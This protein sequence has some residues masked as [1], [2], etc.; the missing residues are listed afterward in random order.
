MKNG[1]ITSFTDLFAWKEGHK[2]VLM[3]YRATDVFPPK[4]QFGLISQMRR[5]ALSVT[6]NIA[7]GFSRATVNDKVQFYTISQ[8]SLTERQNQLL[9]AKDVEYLQ[10]DDFKMI[11]DQTVI[12]NKLIN[13]LRRIKRK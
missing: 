1:K 6:S 5:A 12:V 9:V 7:E 3:I 4:E 8:G 2:L 10:N 13:G 11:A